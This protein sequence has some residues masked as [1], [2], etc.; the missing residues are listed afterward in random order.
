[1]GRLQF[2]QNSGV[3]AKQ[4]AGF[5]ASSDVSLTIV[6]DACNVGFGCSEPVASGASG[7]SEGLRKL[8]TQHL[9]VMATDACAASTLLLLTCESARPGRTPT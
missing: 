1:V 5:A 4:S 3:E 6:N 2:S 9:A 7:K 8:G